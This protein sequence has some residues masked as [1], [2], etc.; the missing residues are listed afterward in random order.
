[1]MKK[2]LVSSLLVFFLSLI[3]AFAYAQNIQSVDAAPTPVPPQSVAIKMADGL[4]I[5]GDFYIPG[6]SEKAPAALLLHQ[7][8]GNSYDWKDFA[9]LLVEKG[10]NVLAVDL[11]G[12]GL[13]GGKADWK[14]AQ[15]DTVALMNWL[16]DQDN[17]DPKHVV[18]MGASVGANLA[19]R[20]CADDDACRVAIALS[21]GLSF[22]GIVAK[23]AISSMKDKSIFLAAS[24]KDQ[25]SGEPTKYLT[26]YAPASVN[27][28]TRV[29]AS[30]AMHGMGLFTFDD[31]TPLIMQ[32]LDKYNSE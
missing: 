32:W 21:P 22:Y 29:Y 13:T 11:R 18:V 24:Q 8:G 2:W 16:R 15:K 23:D 10:Y 27:V 30:S 9:N 17:I 7:Y 25:Q 28:L 3:F 19:L 14:L 1:M 4:E 26:I 31:L 12:Q 5:K 20:G 6:G